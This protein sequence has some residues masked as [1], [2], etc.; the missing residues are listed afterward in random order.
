MS[1]SD[2]PKCWDT[3]CTCGYE[4]RNWAPSKIDRMIE[5]L[6]IVNAINRETPCLDDKA[7]DAALLA[8]T[9]HLHG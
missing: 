8:R 5:V 7:F 6:Q 3:P 1:L 9:E 2:C 4:W